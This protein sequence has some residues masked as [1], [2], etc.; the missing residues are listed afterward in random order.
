MFAIIKTGG[1]QLYIKEGDF[2]WVEKLLGEENDIITFDKVLMIDNEVGSPYIKDALVS[3]SIVKQGKSKKIIVFKYKPKK[4]YHKKYGH[5][6]PYTKLK[7]EL[8][9]K[10]GE[11]FIPKKNEVKTESKIENK[12]TETKSVE[13]TTPI[14]KEIKN[15][16]NKIND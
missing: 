7:I 14:S 6:Q 12:V 9:S 8:I 4:N 15:T 5:R 10:K 16:D 2:I 11:K 3:A 13:N 1:K